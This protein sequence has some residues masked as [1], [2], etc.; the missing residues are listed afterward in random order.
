MTDDVIHSTQCYIMCINWAILANLQRRS[1][2]L[3][4][5]IVLQETHLWLQ[6]LLLPWQLTLFQSPPT[7]F[8]YVSDFLLEKRYTRP[9]LKKNIFIWLLDHV[10]QAPFANMKIER[11]RGPKMSLI[12]GSSGTQY[13]AMAIKL[14]S[15]NSGAHLVESFCKES[16]ISDTNWLRYLF[17]SYL[18]K[19]WLSI[20]RPQLANLHILKT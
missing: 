15:S 19:I 18:I 5:L 3:G 7:W 12:L 1:L 10:Y 6:K 9:Q 13:V 4:R 8:Q 14:L 17:S 16:N 11:Q 20:W 2:K